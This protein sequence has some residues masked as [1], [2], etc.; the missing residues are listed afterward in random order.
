M[1]KKALQALLKERR[2]L[3]DPEAHGLS[4][5]TG[6]G[7]RARGLS[8]Q[9]VDELTTRGVDTYNR[10]ETGRY[11][12]PPVEYLRQVARLFGLNEQ[13]WVSLCRYAGIGD[14]PGP[15]NQSSGLEV[16]GVWQEALNG[17]S[18][19][20]YVTDASWN[21]LAYNKPWADLFPGGRI[22]RN[23]MRWM[24]LDPDARTTLLQ[25]K[26]VWAPLVVPQLRAALTVRTDDETLLQ[27]A[28]DV[29]ADPDL[30][31]IWVAGGAHI[32]PDGDERP[33]LHALHGPGHVT[34]CASEPLGS[35]GARMIVLLF[36]P[37]TKKRHARV[38]ML[39]A[40]GI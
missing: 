31:P 26:E 4:R 32:H 34:M 15:L 37:G 21:L 1:N 11:P 18:H 23:T 29:R 36:H 33:I 27:I 19:M 3:I 28:K 13:E 20:A 17:I 2:E 10:L 16:P 7:R 25:W 8:Q 30:A 40:R 6:R 39:R 5:P 14:P 35:P 12:N 24:L 22:P 9:Q 38:P